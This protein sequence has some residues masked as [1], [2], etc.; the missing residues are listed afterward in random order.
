MGKKVG[1]L[2]LS[3][4]QHR[5]DYREDVADEREHD[6]E[7][8]AASGRSQEIAVVPSPSSTSAA[9]R[10]IFTLDPQVER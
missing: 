3:L 7:E 2:T 4:I 10:W 6:H 9:T 1:R 5:E 8:A